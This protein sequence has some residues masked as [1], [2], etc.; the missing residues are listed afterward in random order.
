MF[1]NSETLE[2][3]A[4]LNTAQ[5]MCAAARTAPKAKGVDHIVT[6]TIT[7]DEKEKLAV[8]ME[9]IGETEGVGFFVRDAGC[10]REAAAVVLIG[11]TMG[12]RNVPYCGLCGFKDCEENI[13]NDGVCSFDPGDLGIAMGS[14]VSIAADD[15]V[16][17]RIMFSAGKAI[18]NLKLLGD[19]VGIAY[20]IP[21]M[22]KGKDAFFDRKR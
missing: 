7:G 13:K 20:G 2:E 21:L 15:R 12:V 17:N 14:A 1:Y 6:A 3:Q 19:D 8:E 22:A 9:R 5:R 4:V 16:D 10:V 18:V 11:T